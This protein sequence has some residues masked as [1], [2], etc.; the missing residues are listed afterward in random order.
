MADITQVKRLLADR[1][2]AVAEHL[3]PNGRKEANEWRVG[4]TAGEK[5]QSLGV[6]LSGAKAGVWADF[7]S[8]EGGDLLDL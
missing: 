2:Q 8:G 3:L 4:S 6:H 5:G 7:A 1:V